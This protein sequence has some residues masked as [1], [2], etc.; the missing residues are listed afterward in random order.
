MAASTG[1]FLKMVHKA[2]DTDRWDVTNLK[3]YATK[4]L[5]LLRAA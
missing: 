4:Y 2:Y 5:R 3:K 1:G